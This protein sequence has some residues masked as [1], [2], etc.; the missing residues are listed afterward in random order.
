MFNWIICA[1]IGH[2]IVNAGVCPFTQKD[3]DVCERCTQMF[4]VKNV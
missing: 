3:Y 4:E 1:V 2:K